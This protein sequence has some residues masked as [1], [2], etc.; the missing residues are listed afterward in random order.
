MH[1]LALFVYYNCDF[2]NLNMLPLLFIIH[3]Y[4]V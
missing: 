1:E 2:F 4:L 3:L